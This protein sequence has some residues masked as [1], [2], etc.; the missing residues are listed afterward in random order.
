MRF[1]AM[2]GHGGPE[3]LAISEMERPEPGPGEVLIRVAG[4]GVNR[5][6]LLQ[7]AGHYPP[8]PG[9]SP[10][11]GLEVAGMVESLGGGVTTWKPGDRVCALVPGGGY[12]EY[13]V[14]P[15]TSCLPVPEHMSLADAAALPE[16][17]LTV[18]A[19][20]FATVPGQLAAAR[21]LP[22]ERLLVQG[23]SSGIGT[24]AIQVSKSLGVHVAVTAGTD[25]KCARCLALGAEAAFNYRG[26]WEEAARAWAGPGGVSVILDMV[27]GDYV[28]KHLRLLGT[29]GRLVQIATL[30]GAE[31]TVHIPT[32]MI[33]RLV[34]TGSTLRPRSVE[35]KGA[36]V[37]EVANAIWPQIQAGAVRAIIA[38][39]FPLD[40]AAEAH[41]LLEGGEITGKILLTVSE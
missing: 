6:D 16:T 14:A 17:L 2:H 33:K 34:M 38:A 31:A 11:L 19:N 10:I 12:A 25:E 28:S 9:S 39:R 7:R 41:R 20:L 8:P 22:G 4:A 29:G 26:D 27:G 15:A 3:V 40:Q 18:W 13:C 21:V 32:I 5:P 23:G 35:Q 30:G 36:I 24:M 37:A 1:V